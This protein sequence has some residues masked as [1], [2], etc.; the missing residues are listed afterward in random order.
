[1]YLTTPL[2][3]E[4]A[5]G[6]F[7]PLFPADARIPA[8]SSSVMATAL[9]DQAYM[10]LH[11]LQGDSA[12]VARN[13]SVGRY[14]LQGLPRGPKGEVQCQVNLA[15]SVSGLLSVQALDLT[16]GYPIRVVGPEYQIVGVH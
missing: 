4:I 3:L 5:G 6:A 16:T 14:R 11:V 1:M 12:Q 2:G 8:A 13:R 9:D 7:L 15:I 10:D